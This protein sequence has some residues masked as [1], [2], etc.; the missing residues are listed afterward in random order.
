MPTLRKIKS[1][2]MLMLKPI[3]IAAHLILPDRTLIVTN[4][5]LYGVL[6]N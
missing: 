4:N 1:A 5:R 2:A 6:K 3:K